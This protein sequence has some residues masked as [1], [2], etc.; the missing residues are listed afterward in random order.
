[1]MTAKVAKIISQLVRPRLKQRAED[2]TIGERVRA[3]AYKGYTH[4]AIDYV[5]KEQRKELE[6][7]GLIKDETTNGYAKKI[8]ILKYL[9]CPDFI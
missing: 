5:D 2:L 1:M 8:K 3:A 7:L 6:E 4:V 9:E